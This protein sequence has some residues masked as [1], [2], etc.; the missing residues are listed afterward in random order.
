[1]IGIE[2][3]G[4]EEFILQPLRQEQ[5]RR[6]RSIPI[7]GMKAP[8][9]KMD[10]IRGLQPFFKAREVFFAKDCP[11]ARTQLLSFP[12]GKIDVPNAMAY[13]LTLRPGQ[14]VYDNFGNLNVEEELSTID[15][16]A[17]LAINSDGSCTSAV[18]LQLI[19]GQLRILADWMKEGGPNNTLED[20]VREAGLLATGRLRCYCP[21][22][23]FSQYDYVG[24]RAAARSIPIELHRGTM[25]ETGRAELRQMLARTT[26]QRPALVV[27]AGSRWSLNALAGG[28]AREVTKG[29]TL[30]FEPV[31]GP[32]RVLMEGVESFAGLLR[33]SVFSEDSPGNYAMTKDGRKYLSSR[34]DLGVGHEL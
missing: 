6:G 32:Y 3:D 23:H 12:T 1:M 16:Q 14:P 34:P 24:M 29:G 10:F 27:S 25:P 31:P 21:P 9:G 4:L 7:R 20:M 30:T 2:R 19:D 13:A 17:Y 33:S 28:F 18:L 26:R 8:K 22:A 5:L 11:D 15:T